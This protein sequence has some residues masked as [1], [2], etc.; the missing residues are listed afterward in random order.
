MYHM[1]IKLHREVT[2][3]ILEDLCWV[4]NFDKNLNLQ[5]GKMKDKK[6]ISDLPSQVGD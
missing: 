4:K 3:Q 1:G 6:K 5:M 2:V